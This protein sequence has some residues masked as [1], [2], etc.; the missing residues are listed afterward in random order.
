MYNPNEL[1]TPEDFAFLMNCLKADQHLP[2]ERHVSFAPVVTSAPANLLAFEELK[3][4]WYSADELS[5]FKSQAR[6]LVRGGTSPADGDESLRGLE[7][8]N[9]LRQ[10]HRRMTIRCTASA[11]RQGLRGE[12]LGS[13]ARK[14]TQ[15]NGD[16]AL[17]QACHDFA[18]V[19]KP[20]MITTIPPIGENPPAFP[21]AVKSKRCSSDN[22][23]AT[24][25]VR[26][27]VAL[28]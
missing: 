9:P 23:G 15:W 22:T 1:P 11:A 20:Q 17:L 27:R 2:Q 12:Q 3:G 25:N 19:Y 8:T 14:C 26:Q 13:V 16:I 5:Q 18:T 7:H 21:F 10:R 24:R 6:N 4:F 28:Q